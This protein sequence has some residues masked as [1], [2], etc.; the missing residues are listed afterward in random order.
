MSADHKTD[1]QISAIGCKKKSN[2][3]QF[4]HGKN[5]N[6]RQ[7]VTESVC[8]F[9]QLDSKRKSR[10]PSIAHVKKSR[11]SPV[12]R[13]EGFYIGLRQSGAKTIAKFV[14]RYQ[15]INIKFLQSAASKYH[16]F[17]QLVVGKNC[18][19]CKSVVSNI[20]NFVNL[21]REGFANYFIQLQRKIAYFASLSLKKNAN[22]GNRSLMKISNFANHS[23][24]KKPLS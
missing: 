18:K 2:F 1:L 8:E 11:I 24:Q 23:Q 5:R 12:F 22:F 6:N 14:N 3:L 4:G 9:H 20:A 17:H 7:S 19:F 16:R 13:W 21:S 15:K 10:I